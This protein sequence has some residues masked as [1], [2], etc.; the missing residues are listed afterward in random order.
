MSCIGF[1]GEA[2]QNAMTLAKASLAASFTP[3]SNIKQPKHSIENMVKLKLG[4]Y[5]MMGAL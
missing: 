3:V 2:Q 1:F 4:L 5:R